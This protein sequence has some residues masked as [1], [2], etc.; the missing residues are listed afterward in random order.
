MILKTG[1]TSLIIAPLF[2]VVMGSAPTL[3]AFVPRGTYEKSC[4]NVQVDGPY[5]TA[6]CARVDGSWRW[7]RIFA[8]RCDGLEISNQNGR[9]TCGE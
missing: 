7:T 8:P 6:I 3:A 4:R 1:A 2:A 5:L 9:L